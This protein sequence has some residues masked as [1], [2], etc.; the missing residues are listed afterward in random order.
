MTLAFLT[1]LGAPYI[2]DISSLRVKLVLT[3][4]WPAFPPPLWAACR[5]WKSFDL[6]IA[7]SLCDQVLVV[8]YCFNDRPSY[9]SVIQ[10]WLQLYSYFD[11][12]HFHIFLFG[13]E[14]YRYS[15]VRE[16]MNI[17]DVGSYQ[18]PV[19]LSNLHAYLNVVNARNKPRK[20][21][22]EI[23]KDN[24]ITRDK[25]W[26]FG[27]V[28]RGKLDAR[29]TGLGESVFVVFFRPDPTRRSKCRQIFELWCT[30]TYR[31]P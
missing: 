18:P 22:R 4:L 11:V 26:E 10:V 29:R 17:G 9:A 23:R 16:R 24:Q 27:K 30:F 25:W 28:W 1:L 19:P 5:I 12:L 3:L 7:L 8:A 15:R 20:R 21:E 14:R 13:Q 6:F 31:S 2:Y